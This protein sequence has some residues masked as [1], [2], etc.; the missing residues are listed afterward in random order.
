MPKTKPIDAEAHRKR[1][2]GPRTPSR[3]RG[4]ARYACLLDATEALLQTEDPDDVGLYQIAERAGVPPASVYHFFPTKEAAYAALAERFLE[5]LSE[6]HNQ[7]IEAAALRSWQDLFR[8]AL[9]RGA[10]FFNGHP[11][12][13]KILYGG[14]AGVESREID[15]LVTLRM[16][17]DTYPRMNRVFHMP[18]LKDPE[19]KFEIWLGI[20]DA[21]WTISVRRNGYITDEYLE[22]SYAASVAYARLFLPEIVERRP[23]LI[24]AAERGEMIS[25]RDFGK[26]EAEAE[27]V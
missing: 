1:R 19:R 26:A 4:I 25:L 10:D 17:G 2:E 5:Q 8:T 15:R 6:A 9:R 22:E 18:Y 7:P 23:E 16:A 12:A 13:L 11:H 24:A 14:H 27:A 20:L 21:I 3:K